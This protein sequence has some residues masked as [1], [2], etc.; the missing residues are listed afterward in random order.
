MRV[1][2]SRTW[3]LECAQQHL[4]RRR[5]P[6]SR[7]YYS[8]LVLQVSHDDHG[9]TSVSFIEALD[10]RRPDKVMAV[11]HRAVLLPH[12]RPEA[13]QRGTPH[14]RLPNKQWGYDQRP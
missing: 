2:R 7:A 13:C 10:V 8:F 12:A 1:A 11:L 5:Q 3:L 9:G 14:Q 4:W 6:S